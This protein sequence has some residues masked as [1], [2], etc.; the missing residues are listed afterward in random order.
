M[1]QAGANVN[2][3]E[4]FGWER[5]PLH[6]AVD[7]KDHEITEVLI[8]NGADVNMCDVDNMTPVYLALQVHD[9]NK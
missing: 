2:V 9:D 6:W 3:T 4:C 5:S 8:A 7:V 1:I